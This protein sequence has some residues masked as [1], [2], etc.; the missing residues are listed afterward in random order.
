MKTREEILKSELKELEK[1]KY[2]GT[3]L[4]VYSNGRIKIY[5][6][7][8]ADREEFEENRQRIKAKL[9][10]KLRECLTS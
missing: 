3:E 1:M 10:F 8:K 7:S 2:K 4:G 5:I 9:E 6:S